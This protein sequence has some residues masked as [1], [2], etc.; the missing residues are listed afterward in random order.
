MET[1]PGMVRNSQGGLF[2]RNVSGLMNSPDYGST[3]R[4]LDTSSS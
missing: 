2:M 1:D 4:C 3:F